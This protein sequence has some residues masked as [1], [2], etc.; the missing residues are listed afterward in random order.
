[1]IQRARLQCANGTMLLPKPVEPSARSVWG[2]RL[3][4]VSRRA[5]N[6]LKAIRG[7]S[8]GAGS[9]LPGTP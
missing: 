7:E 9:C 6:C 4:Y 2:D 3:A 1:M 5:R 8:A